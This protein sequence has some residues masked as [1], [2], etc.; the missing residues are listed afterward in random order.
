MEGTLLRVLFWQVEDALELYKHISAKARGLTAVF[1][2]KGCRK[3]FFVRKTARVGN[4]FDGQF[5]FD[6][7][8]GRPVHSLF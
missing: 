6:Q 3:I 8:L 2:E 5:V 4:L 1:S 7:Q